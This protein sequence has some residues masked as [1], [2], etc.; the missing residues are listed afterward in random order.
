MNHVN[1]QKTSDM[2][3]AVI[4]GLQVK[5][6]DIQRPV[7]LEKGLADL[8]LTA[9]LISNRIDARLQAAVSSASIAVAESAGDGQLERTLQETLAGISAFDLRVDIEGE[10]D[11]YRINISSNID[12]TLKGAMAKQLK[13]KAGV[14]EKSLNDAIADKTRKPLSE[15]SGQLSGLDSIEDELASR[16]G[17]GDAVRKD[18]LKKVG[19]K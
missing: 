8:E 19:L 5:E 11:D 13:K 17:L 9:D 18:A 2:V 10:T 7:Y 6:D 3:T 1:P 15:A 12:D 4:A 16:L 14:F